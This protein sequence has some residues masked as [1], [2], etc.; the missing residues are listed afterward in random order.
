MLRREDRHDL[1]LLALFVAVYGLA[2]APLVHAIYGHGARPGPTTAALGWVTHQSGS[3]A[4]HDERVPHSHGPG[5]K[6]EHGTAPTGHSHGVGSVEHLQALAVVTPGLPC[7]GVFWV[8]LRRVLLGSERP[9]QG[10]P[11][12]LT[13]MP[14]GP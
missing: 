12:P 7:P 1:G 13:A 6:H 14:Q 5:G 8:A 10:E 9:R 4:P 3:P 2:F 11:L